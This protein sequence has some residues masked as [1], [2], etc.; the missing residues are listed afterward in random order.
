MSKRIKTL[1]ATL[2]VLALLGGGYC[3]LAIWENRKA[4][5]EEPS[6]YSPPAELG[7]LDSTEL[8]KIE[9]NGITLEKNNEIWELTYLERGIPPG[10]IELDQMQIRLLAFP[11][12]TVWVESIVDD[13]PEDISVYGLDNPS[14]R[15]V[16][17]DSAGRKAEY[18]LGDMTPSRTSYYVMEKGDPKV[19][20]I[21]VQTADVM[22]VSL[23]S[24]RNRNLFPSFELS[25]LTELRI[26][27]AGRRIE[28]HPREISLHPYLAALFSTHVLT[29]PYKLPRGVSGE[30]LNSLIA[31]LKRLLIADFIDDTPSSLEPYG[32]DKPV[33][34]SLQAENVS[35][36]KAAIDF[37]IG[38]AVNGKYYAKL[39]D[40][41]GIFTLSNMKTIVDAKPFNLIDKFVLLVNIDWVDRLTING[42]G[43]NLSADFQGS[44]DERVF[45]LNGRKAEDKSFKTFYQAVIGLLADAEYPGPSP[46]QSEESGKI[47]IEYQLNTPPGEKASITLLPYD[48]DFYALQQ[49]GAIEFLVSRN[50]VRRIYETAN[51]VAAE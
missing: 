26:T 28:I 37:L 17:T 50:Q 29:S 30:E 11:L 9:A 27:S 42:E 24:I 5:S 33:R 19:Y 44:G 6:Y 13:E 16:I 12:A 22:R 31:P 4:A 15:T 3:V 2:G 10:G 39:T 43:K 36:G 48:R 38:N 14:T 49:E 34:V 18:I 7:N 20:T 25:E 51:A 23:D 8:I 1:V 21:S 47:T 35:E 41:P 46:R 32:L 40:A 45:F